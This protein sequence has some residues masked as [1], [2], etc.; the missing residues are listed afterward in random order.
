MGIDDIYGFPVPL[1]KVDIPQAVLVIAGDDQL[2]VVADDVGGK[3]QR[4]LFSGTFYHPLTAF[5][6]GV[7]LYFLDETVMIVHFEAYICI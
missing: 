7:I 4:P 1:L 6:F 2:A 3:V 5:S